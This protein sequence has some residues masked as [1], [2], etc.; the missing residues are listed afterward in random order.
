MVLVTCPRLQGQADLL[1]LSD[2]VYKIHKIMHF[3]QIPQSRKLKSFEEK[4]LLCIVHSDCAEFRLAKTF[5]N[6]IM[7]TESIDVNPFNVFLLGK[8]ESLHEKNKNSL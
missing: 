4:K 8:K 6:I 5:G 1:A 2:F 7:K 3:L